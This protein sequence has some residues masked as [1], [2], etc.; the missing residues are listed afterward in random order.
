MNDVSYHYPG[1]Q[2]NT[3]KNVTLSVGKG[4]CCGLIGPNG[5][6]KST[7]LSALSGLI[8]P[9]SGDIHFHQSPYEN[10]KKFIQE[11]VALVPQDYAFYPQLSVLQNLNYFVSLCGFGR[12]QRQQRVE[13]VLHQCHLYDVK[14]QTSKALSGGYKRRLNLAIAL[15]KDPLFLYLDEPTVGV[16]PVSRK[17][18]IE[19]IQTLKH[20]GKT[21]IYT[22][23]LLSEVQSICD[24]IIMLKQGEAIQLDQMSN[25]HTLSINFKSPVSQEI[26]QRLKQTFGEQSVTSMKLQIKPESNQALL[27]NLALFAQSEIAVHEIH[28]QA[29]SLTEYYLSLMEHNDTAKH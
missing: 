2:S 23:H 17:A 10:H 22:S 24:K 7:L 29:D 21:L 25:Q 14:Q 20:E 9:T 15:L 12:S 5:A 8:S 1:N 13:T 11:H 27:H 4:Q 18:I 28:Y 19:L 6:G 16:D 3:L 26:L